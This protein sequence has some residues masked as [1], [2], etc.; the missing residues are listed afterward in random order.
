MLLTFSCSQTISRPQVTNASS[1]TCTSSNP[2]LLRSS[3][4][5]ASPK[6]SN[7]TSKINSLTASSYTRA[8]IAPKK[9]SGWLGNVSTKATQS[10]FDNPSSLIIAYNTSA[11]SSRVGSHI[12]KSMRPSRVNGAYNLE[13]SF[14]VTMMGTRAFVDLKS[15]RHTAPSLTCVGLSQMFINVP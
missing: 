6:S 14:P 15:L 10:S 9:S 7:P 11:S 12:H 5:S 8:L 1:V 13:K 3:P 2:T 4:T